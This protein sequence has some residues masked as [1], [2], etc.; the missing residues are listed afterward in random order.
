MK[1]KKQFVCTNCGN[2]TPKWQGRCPQ[3]GEWNTLAEQMVKTAASTGLSKSSPG[4]GFSGQTQQLSEVVEHAQSRFLSGLG[5]FDSVLGGGL[6]QGSLVLLGGDPGIGKSTL[7]LQLASNIAAGNEHGN[8]SVLYVSGEESA[9]QIKMRSARLSAGADMA[10]LTET[11]LDVVVAT[12]ENTQP[13]LVIID[14]IQTLNSTSV[15]GVVGGV[16]QLSYSTNALMRLA[17]ANNVAIILIGHVTKEGMLAGPKTIEHMVDVVLYLEGDR[18]GAL[19]LLRSSKNRFGSVGEVG[20]FEMNESG[21]VEV[22]NPSAMFLEHRDKPLPGSC[23]T[24][25]IEGN[26]VLLIEIQALTNTT[27]LSYPRRVA[28]GFDANRLQLLLAIMQKSLNINLSN[29]DVYV[30]VAG[31]YK[32]QERAADLPVVMA[33]LSSYYGKAI[34]AGTIAFGEVGLLGEVRNVSQLDK[35][36]KE[37]KK[38]GFDKLVSAKDTKTLKDI[39][40]K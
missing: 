7:A 13:N 38:L 2:A 30:N 25:T 29:Q 24:A 39:K 19:R 34:P 31:G 32:V 3:C 5:E 15:N 6:V 12:V 26:K 36:S 9:Q 1:L 4:A 22:P 27:T 18:F 17:K 14:S 21:L 16:S 33:I 20:I 35:R 10:I 11:D 28:S 23:V 40:I 37:A 8:K